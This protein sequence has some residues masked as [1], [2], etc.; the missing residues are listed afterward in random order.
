MIINRTNLSNLN[1]GFK[2]T[3]NNAFAGVPLTYTR[4]ATVVP[5][6]TSMET[7]SWMV[8]TAGM[9]EW[10][11]D[12]QRQALESEAYKLA[13]K[14]YEETVEVPRDAI[15]DDEYGIFSPRM[16]MMGENAAVNP[17]K[18]DLWRGRARRF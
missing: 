15:E 12:R 10:I 8:N 6:S 1:V 9:R 5:S 11:G 17:E 13:N 14:K 16:A 3:F 7:Y 2:T 4:I 18:T